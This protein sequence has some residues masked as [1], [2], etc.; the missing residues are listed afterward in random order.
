MCPPRHGTSGK[1]PSCN[2]GDTGLIPNSGRSLGEGNSNPFQYYCWRIPWT[3]EAGRLQSM[4]LQRVRQDLATKQDQ[5]HPH[6][7]YR[8][9]SKITFC[10][11][12]L[13]E[14]E[15]YPGSPNHAFIAYS[16][17]RLV[18]QKYRDVLWVKSLQL[19]CCCLHSTDFQLHLLMEQ[20]A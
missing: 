17:W 16:N 3:E 15:R 1:E 6:S 4:G 10:V 12:C 20:G 2:A 19:N 11:W 13:S 18:L 7:G 5:Q 9:A 14:Q 8:R